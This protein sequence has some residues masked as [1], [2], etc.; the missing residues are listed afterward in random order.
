MPTVETENVDVEL[1]GLAD[2]D[3]DDGD[4]GDA[5]IFAQD[6]LASQPDTQT[7]EDFYAARVVWM[8]RL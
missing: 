6:D 3:G 2:D 5:N 4:A 8:K 1:G 7:Y